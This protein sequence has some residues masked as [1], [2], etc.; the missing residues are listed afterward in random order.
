[1][2]R[3]SLAIVLA[4]LPN[5]LMLQSRFHRGTGTRFFFTD[6]RGTF[7]FALTADIANPIPSTAT[8]I[9]QPDDARPT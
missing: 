2:F 3:L 1:M 6:A 5:S 7:F 4:I 9:R 8:P